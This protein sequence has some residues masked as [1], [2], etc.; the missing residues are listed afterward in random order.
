MRKKKRFREIAR[1]FITFNCT[2]LKSD[3]DKRTT[4][5]LW[6]Y[7]HENFS[8]NS[9]GYCL[10]DHIMIQCTIEENTETGVAQFVTIIITPKAIFVLLNSLTFVFTFHRNSTEA[11]AAAAA[12]LAAA[13]AAAHISLNI[14]FLRDRCFTRIHYHS[15]ISLIFIRH[16]SSSVSCFFPTHTTKW[17]LIRRVNSDWILCVICRIIGVVVN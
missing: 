4:F 5:S 8:C 16:L 12:S 13:A 11:A 2:I 3:W 17:I 9:I 10:Y 7:S 6:R 1:E 15:S 14:Y